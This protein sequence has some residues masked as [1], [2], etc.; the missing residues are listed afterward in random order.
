M[1]NSQD[2]YKPSGIEFNSNI[3]N[4]ESSGISKN[5]FLILE[6]NF[7]KIKDSKI[8][9]YRAQNTSSYF[10]DKAKFTYTDNKK[11]EVYF[12]FE[13]YSDGL[14][15]RTR[16]LIFNTGDDPLNKLNFIDSKVIREK[17]LNESFK[18][19]R[20]DYQFFKLKIYDFHIPQSNN[21]KIKLPKPK[22]TLYGISLGGEIKYLLDSNSNEIKELNK[23]L[24]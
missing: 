20:N 14:E 8:D 1:I 17:L 11:Y 19:S 15:Y 9:W 23:L 5:S 22:H 16:I 2:I 13:S 10:L 24:K 4:K 12:D 3:I 21:L 18:I 7:K 6:N